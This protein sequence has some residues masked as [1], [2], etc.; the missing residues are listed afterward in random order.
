MRLLF[1][2]R[3]RDLDLLISD[4]VTNNSQLLFHRS[5]TDRLARIAPFLRYDKDPYLV[6][7]D[8]GRLVYVQDAY[9]TSDR[10]PNAQAFDPPSRSS[11]PG[12]ASDEFNYIRNSVKI[13]MD[14]YD[15]TMHFYVSDPTD[16]IIR[17]YQGVFPTLFEPLRRDA[18][19]PARPP[20]RPGGAVQRPDPRVRPLPRHRTRSSSSGPTTCGRCRPARRASR[21]CRPRRTTS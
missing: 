1:A 8:A 20:A 14:A 6:I 13:T 21:R 16:P 15:G 9:T 11:R 19:R 5:L 7:D 18:R 4:Q 2:L 17:A 3:F 12:S 10:F